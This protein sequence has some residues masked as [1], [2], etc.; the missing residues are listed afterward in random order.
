MQGTIA[1]FRRGRRTQ[2]TNHS[3]IHFNDVDSRENASKLVGKEVVWKSPA[4]KEI[5][6][7]VASAHG[8]KGSVRVIF[9]TGMPG[10]SIGSKVQIK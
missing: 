10:Q 7:K 4:G 9:E 5:K 6:G 3:I 2:K 1:N 8:N